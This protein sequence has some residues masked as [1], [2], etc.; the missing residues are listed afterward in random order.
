[1]SS[2]FAR[3][4]YARTRNTRTAAWVAAFCLS[5]VMLGGGV[6]LGSSYPFVLGMWS[7]LPGAFVTAGLVARRRPFDGARRMSRGTWA[8]CLVVALV[9]A[10]CVATA[11]TPWAALPGV[12]AAWFFIF[13]ASCSRLAPS[14]PTA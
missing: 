2:D 12:L 9:L 11:L 14:V 7:G 10:T 6:A 5:V 8:L 1:M 13:A 3:A 4:V